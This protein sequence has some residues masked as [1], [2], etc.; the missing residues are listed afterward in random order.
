M[1]QGRR[2]LGD[3]TLLGHKHLVGDLLDVAFDKF[4]HGAAGADLA[5]HRVVCVEFKAGFTVAREAEN[6]RLFV[7]DELPDQHN[8]YLRNG[9]YIHG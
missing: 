2:R 9:T 6:G 5:H 4:V 1:Q 8:P 3:K 7:N